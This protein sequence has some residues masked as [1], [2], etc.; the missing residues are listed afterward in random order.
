MDTN[1]ILFFAQI[2]ISVVLIILIAF[3]QRG[4]ALGASFGGSGGS[5][6]YSARRG[7]Q[8]KIYYATIAVAALFIV[9]GILNILI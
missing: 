8:K 1:Q 5:E 2:G 9:L 3:Q 4:T 6:F 7:I